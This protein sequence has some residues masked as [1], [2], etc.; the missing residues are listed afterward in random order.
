MFQQVSGGAKDSSKMDFII[1]LAL[2]LLIIFIRRLSE[3]F[4]AFAS[5]FNIIAQ[6]FLFGAIVAG[7][8]MLYERR[9]CSY[10]YSIVYDPSPKTDEEGNV[11]SAPI[12]WKKGTF[13]FERMVAVKGKVIEAVQPEEFVKL[14]KPEKPCTDENGNAVAIPISRQS[15]L[16]NLPAKK[17]YKLIFRRSGRLYS[18]D[19]SPDEEFLCY[20]EKAMQPEAQAEQA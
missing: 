4:A 14:I 17:A 5:P 19:F 1:I 10:R 18:I 7:L 11:I 6:V 12:T 15:K 13:L 20:V 16:T 3:L 8:L 9:L 2:V